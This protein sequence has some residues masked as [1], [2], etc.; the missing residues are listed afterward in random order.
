[1]TAARATARVPMVLPSGV[2]VS[3]AASM[4]P[5]MTM[6]EMALVTAIRGVCNAGVTFHTT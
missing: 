1:M 3:A 2:T 4:A 5:T 6:A